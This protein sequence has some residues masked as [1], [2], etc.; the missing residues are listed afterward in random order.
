MNFY[1]KEHKKR[2]SKVIDHWSGIRLLSK[3]AA[4]YGIKDIF[5]DNGGK[6]LQQ[7]I[8]LDFKNLSG[9]EGNDAIDRN[10]T[11]WEMKSAN[12]ALVSGFSTHHHLNYD[13]LDKYKLVPW[14]FAFYEHSDLS[15]IYVLSPKQM[16]PIFIDWKH[17]LDT[18]VHKKTGKKIEHIN[19]PKIPLKF[20][21]ENGTKVW[22]VDEKNPID[23]THAILK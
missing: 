3:L 13:I 8:I 1:N 4:E 6:I 16:Q 15:E 23:P 20:V 10:G 19:N 2:I 18:G 14:S 17:K 21:R 22:P 11:E 9:R 7:L 12:E 5:Q